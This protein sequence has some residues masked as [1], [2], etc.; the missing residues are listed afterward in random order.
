MRVL[1]VNDEAK[2]FCGAKTYF[3]FA[4]FG[5]PIESIITNDP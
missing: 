4:I 2:G 1:F 3:D 5:T